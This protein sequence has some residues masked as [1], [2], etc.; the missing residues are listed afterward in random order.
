MAG[1]SALCDGST[2][3]CTH[4]RLGAPV[5]RSPPS[6]RVA[7]RDQWQAPASKNGQ[8]E[9]TV[10][11][12]VTAAAVTVGLVWRLVWREEATW[13]R[14]QQVHGDSKVFA[15]LVAARA[16]RATLALSGLMVFSE[17]ADRGDLEAADR[18]ALA[19]AISA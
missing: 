3:R 4:L 1:A 9:T 7:L 18:D 15:K 10:I 14:F 2:I 8:E 13:R 17:P 12:L 5:R 11:W 19:P 16:D 6:V